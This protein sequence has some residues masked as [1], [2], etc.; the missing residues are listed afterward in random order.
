M[1]PGN[2]ADDLQVGSTLETVLI[3]PVYAGRIRV[4]R[5]DGTSETRGVGVEAEDI[6]DAIGQGMIARTSPQPN[7]FREVGL[8]DAAH[9]VLILPGRQAATQA[10]AAAS[11]SGASLAV[12]PASAPDPLDVPA[13]MDWATWLNPVAIAA[14]KRGEFVV[15]EKGGWDSGKPPYTALRFFKQGPEGR[16]MSG[17]EAEPAPTGEPWPGN[18]GPEQR[19]R[20][21]APASPDAV[22]VAG[23]LAVQAVSLWALTP[24]DVVLTFVRNPDGRWSSAESSQLT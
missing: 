5:G 14:A 1:N 23:L 24:L 4:W 18:P 11:I 17:I 20:V 8:L 21:E 16:W 22:R 19:S 3:S 12:A 7:S 2:P 6:I 10:I 15:V 13:W 9:N